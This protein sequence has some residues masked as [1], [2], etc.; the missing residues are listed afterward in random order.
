[1]KKKI[2]YFFVLSILSSYICIA[3]DSLRNESAVESL[4]IAFITRQ[5]N[6][7]PE[8][9]Q[10]FWPIY[11]MYTTELRN[12][13][14]IVSSNDILALEEYVLDVRKKYKAKFLTVL[15]LDRLNLFYKSE[16]NFIEFLHRHLENKR[17]N[18]NN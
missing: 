7:S 16:R 8:E 18:K 15:S 1:M 4:K 14:E 10:K 17:K 5:I 2:A 9:A 6:L 3:Q 12:R 11:N 13:R